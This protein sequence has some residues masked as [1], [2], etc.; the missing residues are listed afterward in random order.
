MELLKFLY[1][2]KN[3][4]ELVYAI[5]CM[6]IINSVIGTVFNNKK[7][8]NLRIFAQDAR[9]NESVRVPLEAFYCYLLFRTFFR[10]QISYKVSML[11]GRKQ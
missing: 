8:Q 5:T 6:A 1:F 2:F 3:I 7:K 9:V 10:C 4:I 11:T